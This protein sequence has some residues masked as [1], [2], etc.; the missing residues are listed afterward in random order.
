VVAELAGER[1]SPGTAA[2]VRELLGGQALAD[3][4]TWADEIRDGR[5]GSGPLHFVNIPITA[6]AYDPSRDCPG[7]RCIIAAIDSFAGVL[8]DAEVPRP[9]RAEAL[10][11]L[12]HLVA[13]LH[14]PL[15]VGDNHDKGGN[16]TQVRLGDTGTNLHAVWD[17]QL[18]E[19]LGL[20]ERAY[21][22]RLHARMRTLDLAAYER[23]TVVSWAMEGHRVA[24]DL[25]YRFPRNRRLD[26]A[27]VRAGLEQVDLALIKAGV[28]LAAVLERALAGYR[29]AVPAAEVHAAGTYTDAEAGAHVGETATVVGVVVS[30][31]VS[32]A[33]NT[34]LNFGGDYP[35]QTFSVVLLQPHHPGQ[36]RLLAMKGKRVA[37]RGPIRRY[38]GGPEI[39]IADPAAVR[40]LP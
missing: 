14:Q 16:Q 18:I 32:R 20:D 2:A 7:G 22:A 1:L 30:A 38:Q 11:F 33:G 8:A 27:Y 37:V 39:V 31:R 29:T 34:F 15:H 13:D 6:A 35:H 9:E 3:A 40:V 28:R 4:S 24:R 21:L 10:R 12:V 23:G 36:G 19:A 5:G 25:A 17:G 26:S